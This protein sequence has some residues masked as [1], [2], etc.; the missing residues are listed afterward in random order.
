MKKI[1]YIFL[2]ILATLS[3]ISCQA[4]L[5]VDDPID[6]PEGYVKVEIDMEAVFG[7]KELS[8][9]AG[10]GPIA[11][12]YEQAITNA[13]ICVFQFSGN[14]SNDKLLQF[15]KVI[16]DINSSGVTYY[17]VLKEEKQSVILHGFSNIDQATIN[18]ISAKDA[19]TDEYIIN[20]LQF[21]STASIEYDNTD[22]AVILRNSAD[23]LLPKF[24]EEI[25]L[26][27]LTTETIKTV[28]AVTLFSYA[29][30][31][32]MMPTA[33]EYP[34]IL[35][36]RVANAPTHPAYLAALSVPIEY[37]ESHETTYLNNQPVYGV[38]TEAE[39]WPEPITAANEGTKFVQGLYMYPTS[40]AASSDI[41][42]ATYVILRVRKDENSPAEGTYYKLL[43]RHKAEG[44]SEFNYDIQASHRYLVKVHAINTDGYATAAEA[45]A[46]PPSNV[47]YDIII[48]DSS[49]SFTTNGQYYIGVAKTE[50]YAATNYSQQSNMMYANPE[51]INEINLE[52]FV[53]NSDGTYTF[54]F[55]FSYNAGENS[56]ILNSSLTKSLSIPIGME[57]LS[58]PGYNTLDDWDDSF[59][60]KIL[61]LKTQS[62]YADGEVVIKVGELIHKAT[63][64]IGDGIVTDYTNETFVNEL[65]GLESGYGDVTGLRVANAYMATPHS[66]HD[67][68][69]FIPV[70]ERINE[71][72]NTTNGYAGTEPTNDYANLVNTNWTNNTNYSVELSWYDGANID[73]LVVEKAYSPVGKNA[74]KVT[75]PPGFEYQNIAINV[76]Y[77][78]NIIWSWHLW[79]TDYNPY[80][81]DLKDNESSP[82][83]Y[84]IRISTYQNEPMVGENNA[85]HSYA[86][87]L[88]NTGSIYGDKFI[89][90][91]NLGALGADFDGHG[92]QG[93]KKGILFYQFGRKDPFTTNRL[94]SKHNS[95]VDFEYVVKSPSEYVAVVSQNWSNQDS[96]FDYIWNDKK[97][98]KDS[99]LTGKQKSIFDPSP[100][101]FKIPVNVYSDVIT[102]SNVTFETNI[103]MK[104]YLEEGFAFFPYAGYS[105]SNGDFNYKNTEL[106]TSLAK[107]E[108]YATYFEIQN[109]TNLRREFSHARTHGFPVRPI[110]E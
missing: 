16:R 8:T 97:I 20:R 37:V 91:R 45:I 30:I 13:H 21:Y 96:N 62:K 107:S 5:P 53:Y 7:S 27:E 76:K 54:D 89:M 109:T 90:D 38:T 22:G 10:D 24:T 63:I 69:I 14:P 99:L 77:G 66:V 93:S 101:G 57:V 11:T 17:A 71:F 87:E 1:Q 36:T 83:A 50:Y 72:W 108:P 51:I 58:E 31:D 81:T 42:A 49:T 12:Q 70:A 40:T 29:R 67:A 6:I 41:G 65:T 68:V 84:P 33:N 18:T 60:S 92:A 3:L 35:G 105:D 52:N 73:N 79:V 28:T 104:Y 9:R 78:T 95:K 98:S 88:W 46:G 2:T 44:A 25:D 32:V 39:K 74:I 106:W 59:G 15:E 61:R 85:L 48:D 86:G 75:L 56:G 64:L 94:N 102:S 23:G 82:L 103:G 34:I 43:M 47:V 100:L 80:F 110:Q 26:P 55:E 4:E 19:G